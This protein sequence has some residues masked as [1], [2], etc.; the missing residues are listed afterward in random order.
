MN[1]ELCI[2]NCSVPTDILPPR[3]KQVNSYVVLSFLPSLFNLSSR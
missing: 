3:N 2:V 1:Y